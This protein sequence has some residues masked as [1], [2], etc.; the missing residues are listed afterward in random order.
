MKPLEVGT[1]PFENEY[2]FVLVFGEDGLI[3]KVLEM[4]DSHKTLALHPRMTEI[5]EKLRETDRK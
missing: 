2:I 3:E 5:R 1:T 4:V